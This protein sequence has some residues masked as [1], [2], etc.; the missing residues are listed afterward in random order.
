MAIL[1]IVFVNAANKIFCTY[2]NGVYP[3]AMDVSGLP[4]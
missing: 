2:N 1:L 3:Y 4:S